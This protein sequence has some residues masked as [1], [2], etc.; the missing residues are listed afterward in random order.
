MSCQS[1]TAP[2]HDIPTSKLPS[3]DGVFGGLGSVGGTMRC[4]LYLFH[5]LF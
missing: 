2:H 4:P 1:A 5:R 3:W